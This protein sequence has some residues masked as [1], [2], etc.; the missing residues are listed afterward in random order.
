MTDQ[1][2]TT[3][4]IEDIVA[5]ARDGFQRVADALNTLGWDARV[6]GNPAS[7]LPVLA[8]RAWAHAY[9]R[10]PVTLYAYLGVADMPSEAA[11]HDHVGWYALTASGELMPSLERTTAIADAMGVLDSAS[12]LGTHVMRYLGGT[13]GGFTFEAR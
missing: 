10:T 8:I 13:V 1:T 7:A 2:T 3:S 6:E 11:E 5:A 9:G 12:G 4:T